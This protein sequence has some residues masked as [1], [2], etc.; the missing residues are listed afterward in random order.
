M[1][2][3]YDLKIH[4]CFCTESSAFGSIYYPVKNCNH[5]FTPGMSY[6]IVNFCEIRDYIGSSSAIG[7]HI[8]YPGFLRYMLTHHIDHVIHGLNCIQSTPSF[9]RCSGSMG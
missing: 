7:Y 1:S 5:I 6:I 2:T 4:C 3:A 8:M 9:F